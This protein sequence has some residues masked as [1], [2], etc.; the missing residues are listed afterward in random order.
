MKEHYI[1]YDL[2]S[3]GLNPLVDQI[4]CICARS[5][6][7]ERFIDHAEDESDEGRLIHHFIEWLITHNSYKTLLTFNGIDFDNQFLAIRAGITGNENDFM[8]LIETMRNRVQT[9]LC[10]LTYPKIS[11]NNMAMLYGEKKMYISGKI[12]ITMFKNAVKEREQGRVKESDNLFR[13][14]EEYCM[15]DVVLT[16][17]LYLKMRDIIGGIKDAK[18]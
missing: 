2:E 17:K 8:D 11:L 4:T 10:Q 5:S 16:E 12:A 18:D 6:D 14:L 15:S 3:C 13:Q 1:C 9:D 7:G